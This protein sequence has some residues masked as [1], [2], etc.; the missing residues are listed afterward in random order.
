MG[1]HCDFWE[2]DYT[3]LSSLLDQYYTSIVIMFKYLSF[4][5]TLYI[6][7]YQG[8]LSQT[9][10]IHGTTEKRRGSSLILSNTSTSS[11]LFRHL[12]TTLNM[13][14]LPNIFNRTA[15]DCYPWITISLSDDGM[16][17]S[18]LDDFS[19]RFCYSNFGT[20]KRRILIRIDYHPRIIS[21]PTDQKR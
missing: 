2:K 6:F 3:W 11:Q 10:T 20:R 1:R 8:F 7:F 13:R 4:T 12:F 5:S 16:L 15:C 14:W 19:S 17:I 9:L 21:E 18:V